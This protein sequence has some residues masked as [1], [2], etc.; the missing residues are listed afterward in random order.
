MIQSETGTV[1]LIQYHIAQLC[2]GI[3][4]KYHVFQSKMKIHKITVG[5]K[6]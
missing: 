6:L 2:L 5:W 4:H 1:S 3:W